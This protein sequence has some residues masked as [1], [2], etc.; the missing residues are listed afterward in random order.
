MAIY[1]KNGT[2]YKT[3]GELS[4]LVPDSPSHDLF[5]LWDQEGIRAGGT[6]LLY[7]EVF[8]PKSTIDK[9]YLES[10]DKLWSQHP[11]EI[12]GVYDPVPSM[13]DQGLFGIDGPDTI[14]FYTN[15]QDTLS[16]LGHLPIIGS[17][18][19]TPHLR[20]NWEV[21]DRKLGDFHRWKVY[22]V[23]IH[24]QRFQEN[25]TTGEGRVTH[26]SDPSPSF[27]ID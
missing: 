20:E 24:C 18:I 1:N 10:R 3:T 6:P 27:E 11:V 12:W 14:V 4:Q 13:L 15:Y 21:V 19:F 25:L 9:I 16:K 5:N 22:R 7:Y 2:R 8:I 23:E 26:D 17:R